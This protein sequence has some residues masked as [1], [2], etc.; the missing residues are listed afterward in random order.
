MRIHTGLTPYSCSQCDQTFRT[1]HQR[2]VH[3]T[4][5]H[6]S[7]QNV[8]AT[9]D[10]NDDLVPLIISAES[11][12]SALKGISDNG[13]LDSGETLFRLKPSKPN[14]FYPNGFIFYKWGK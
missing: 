4:R 13:S 7:R 9:A 8:G 10:T 11:L 5:T 3:V 14:L 2:Q 12:I 1:P 6:S